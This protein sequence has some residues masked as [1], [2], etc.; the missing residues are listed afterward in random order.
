VYIVT[1]GPERETK[2]NTIVGPKSR[3]TKGKASDRDGVMEKGAHS[4]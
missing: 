1:K 4:I 3:R 2:T